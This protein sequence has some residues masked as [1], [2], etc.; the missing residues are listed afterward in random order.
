[1]ITIREIIE[2]IFISSLFVN[3]L[4][5][6]PQAIKIFHDKSAKDISLFTFLGFLII[7]SAIVLHGVIVKDYL[8]LVG[9][10]LSMLTCGTVVALIIIYRKEKRPGLLSEDIN[11]SEVLKQLPGHIYWKDKNGVY[12]GCNIKNCQDFGLKSLVEIVGKTDHDLFSKDEANNIQQTDQEV[13]LSAQLKIIEEKVTTADGKQTLYLSHKVPLKNKR[14]EVIGILGLSMDITAAKHEAMDQLEMLENII[15]A[16][17][18]NV[19][20]MNREGVY[21]G[22]NDNEAKAIGLASRRDIVGKRNIDIPGFLI[23]EALDPVNK[24]VM[25]QGKQIQLEE[26]ALLRDGTKATFISSKVPLYNDRGEISGMVGIS[27]DITERRKTEQELVETRHK[28]DGMTLVSASIAHELRTPL[29]T[30]SLN[31]VGLKTDLTDLIYA[32][33]LAEKEGLPIRKF[34]SSYLNHLEDA[35][36]LIEREARAAFT[37]IDMLLKN[38]QSTPMRGVHSRFSINQCIQDA[39]SRYPFK[40]EQ[41]KLIHWQKNDDFMVEGSVELVTHVLFNLIK[42]A[43]YYIA[44]ASKGE[45][46]LWLTKDKDYNSVYFKDTGFGI[47]KDKLPFIFD[48]FFSQTP[49]GAGIGLTFC[50]MVMESLGGTI[51]CESVE[52]EYTQ[53]TLHFPILNI[54]QEDHETS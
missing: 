22:C 40:G 6:I 28:L 52:K 5:F 35:P 43:L 31:A 23:P 20:W 50:K 7:Q 36:T 41:R 37:I 48:R 45:I 26:P 21:L 12:L 30:I 24:E 29:A 49:H 51:A 16:M 42:N 27:I 4:L 47:A 2:F 54:G 1:M 32:Y 18:A 44:H 38:L 14:G 25:E 53:F 15:S 46:I 8:L 39:L 13:M 19:Y 10:L 33:Q 3:A 9:Y 17:P 34:K 11:L